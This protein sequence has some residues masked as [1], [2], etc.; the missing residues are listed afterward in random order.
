MTVA[1]KQAI[2]RNVWSDHDMT[3]G[4]KQ[5]ININVWSDHDMTCFEASYKQ[6]CLV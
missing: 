1:L 2:N 6:K 5:A 4:L 3:V